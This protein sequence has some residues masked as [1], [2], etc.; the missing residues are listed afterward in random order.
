MELN[1]IGKEFNFQS[2]NSTLRSTLL[3]KLFPD[4]YDDE[5][6]AN[7]G[8]VENNFYS[9][10]IPNE[11]DTSSQLLFDDN[12]YSS[13]EN[14]TFYRASDFFSQLSTP[15]SYV[16]F[17]LFIYSIIVFFVFISAVYSHRK[18]IGYNYSD[19][20][21]D[22]NTDDELDDKTKSCHGS[23]QRLSNRKI[24]NELSCGEV[25]TRKDLNSRVDNE[26]QNES[27]T[28]DEHL[29]NNLYL[30]DETQNS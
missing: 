15:L 20:L 19:S 21:D 12:L 14:E 30:N 23:Q 16:L 8:L 6:V 28:E 25:E 9:P 5:Q 3:P 11:N 24:Y 27:F 18:R 7:E 13:S 4:F 2:A 26:F 22:L 1:Q 29:L 10:L 17:M